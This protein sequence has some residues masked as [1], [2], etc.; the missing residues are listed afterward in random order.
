MNFNL[1]AVRPGEDQAGKFLVLSDG[2]VII[3]FFKRHAILLNR[4]YI[5]ANMAYEDPKLIG[6]G[7]FYL[8]GDIQT[9]ESGLKN[10][11]TP[12]A[13]RSAIEVFMKQQ[14]PLLREMF[15]ELKK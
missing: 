2:T 1:V 9:W 11:T 14:A 13:N 15:L 8:D 10:F 3:G 12:S 5:Q 4:Y 6:A 7:M